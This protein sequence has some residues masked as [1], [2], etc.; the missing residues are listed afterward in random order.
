MR[1]HYLSK[2][3]F[4]FSIFLLMLFGSDILAQS[5]LSYGPRSKSMAGAG[6]ALIENSIWGNMNPG[7]QVFLGQKFVMGL[8]VLMPKASYTV[9]GEPSEI[10][11]THSS[12][13]PLGIEE[14]KVEAES[15]VNFIPQVGLNLS[16][17]EDN[18]I[19]ICIY[20]NT[21]RGQ[22]YEKK[23]YYSPVIAGW[24]SSEEL[25]NP[26]GVVSSPSFLKLNQYFA[27]FTYSRKLGDKLGLGISWVGAWQSFSVGGLEAFGSL[28][29]SDFPQELTNN[30][31]ANSFGFGGKLGVQWNISEKFQAGASFRTRLYMSK[32]VAY[33]GFIS[34]SGKLD[35]PSEWS[36]GVLYHPFE[37]FLMVLDANRIC[38]SG[39]PAWGLAMKQ[40]GSITL[41]GE[42]GGGFGRMDQMNYKFGIQY[43]LP[44][45]Q[46]RAGYQHSDVTIVAPEYLLNIL[47]PEV[48]SDYI[49]F[50]LTREI[51]AQ[52]MTFAIV[53]GL[54][55]TYTGFNVMDDAQ[56][57]DLSAESLIFELAVEF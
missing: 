21:N 49:S 31:T 14:G 25:I 33:Q 38:Y 40:N 44:K 26:M 45:W 57:I 43:K 10:G 6:T 15:Q 32:M 37:R 11:T 3:L 17:D 4:L 24:G 30:E 1:I 29:Y 50:G 12:L 18:S 46:F 52:K 41:G 22:Q 20:G 54:K 28:H 23:T 5:N 47:M 53:K 39:V 13:W 48:V 27:A 9:I 55:N 42:N 34:E 7:G 16:I 8:E 36:I 35:V 2:H 19:G 56:F 51:G